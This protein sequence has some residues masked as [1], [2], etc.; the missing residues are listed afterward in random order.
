M[1]LPKTLACN[2]KV[3]QLYSTLV[4][5]QQMCIYET[6]VAGAVRCL[7]VWLQFSSTSSCQKLQ[8]PYSPIC[9]LL[10]FFF[11]RLGNL[12]SLQRKCWKWLTVL[13]RALPILAAFLTSGFLQLLTSTEPCLSVR[14]KQCFL[15]FT[16]CNIWELLWLLGYTF[17]AIPAVSAG[18][19]QYPTVS[20]LCG[21]ARQC[22]GLFLLC[23]GAAWALGWKDLLSTSL[24]VLPCQMAGILGYLLALH[25]RRT[26]VWKGK[27][28]FACWGFRK[29]EVTGA[30]CFAEPDTRCQ[31]Q[32]FHK[33]VSQR[34][35]G[36]F[37]VLAG[38]YRQICCGV[39]LQPPHVHVVHRYAVVQSSCH[40]TAPS[41]PVGS[42]TNMQLRV[43]IIMSFPNHVKIVISP[44]SHLSEGGKGVIFK[45]STC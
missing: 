27:W 13:L 16:V 28:S 38:S 6:S 45:S 44:R 31:W 24:Q 20:S 10:G 32:G 22:N 17:P 5:R 43:K 2:A 7:D 42:H 12:S 29:V 11:R 4:S 21:W 8:L 36:L 40:S 25:A 34:P 41:V 1:L 35:H 23:V 15:V 9:I 19:R 30:W 14:S 33:D 39:I 26:F 18:C 3:I 37:E